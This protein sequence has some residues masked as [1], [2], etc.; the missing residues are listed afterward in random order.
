MN[1]L[2]TELLGR[3]RP[4][5][6]SVAKAEQLLMDYW[7]DKIAV[8]WS[9]KDVHRAANEAKTVLTEDQARTILRDLLASYQPQ[10]GL[11]WR[12][13]SEAVQQSGLGR[14]ISKREL[15]RFIHRD[16]LAIDPPEKD[17]DGP[18]PPRR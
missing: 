8:L 14:D 1:Q 3:L 2:I 18:K 15:H 9:T 16:V 6:K 12:D 13:V 17:S 5:L 11:G 7:A 10:Y 4:A